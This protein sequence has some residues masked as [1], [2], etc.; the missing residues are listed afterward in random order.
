[1]PFRFPRKT[2][3]P[4]DKADGR[5]RRDVTLATECLTNAGDELLGK[6][7]DLADQNVESIRCDRWPFWLLEYLRTYLFI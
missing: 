1:M 5:P 2:R 3:M 6:Y 4:A 7:N